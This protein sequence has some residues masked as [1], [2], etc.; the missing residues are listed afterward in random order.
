MDRD[1]WNL[2]PAIS[3]GQTPYGPRYVIEVRYQ[4]TSL[5]R[6]HCGFNPDICGP[7]VVGSLTVSLP[8]IL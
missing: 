3:F 5:D 4:D 6:A 1:Y 8:P 2:G 7:A